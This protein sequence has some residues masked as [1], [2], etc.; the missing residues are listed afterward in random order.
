MTEAEWLTCAD[1]ESMLLH[2]ATAAEEVSP[3]DFY[4]EAF[5]PRSRKLR[6]FGCACVRRKWG[7]LRN[8]LAQSSVEVTEKV[9]DGALAVDR[10]N[11][12]RGYVGQWQPAFGGFE[13]EQARARDR[14]PSLSGER[15]A[16]RVALRERD[17][18][19]AVANSARELAATEPQGAILALVRE[20]FDNP[21]RSVI[22]PR[23][24]QTVDV[25]G[26]AK[27]AYLA[28]SFDSLPILADALEDAGCTDRA[29][30]DHLRGPGPHVRGCWALDLLLGKE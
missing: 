30:L 11:E 1:P 16:F 10:L 21:F 25:L 12:I 15:L 20:V 17:V 28:R 3:L 4:Y 22:L 13:T 29:L 23:A 2:L 14:D 27:G 9:V 26:L 7:S 24:W 8:W 18:W 19:P 5:S 6:L